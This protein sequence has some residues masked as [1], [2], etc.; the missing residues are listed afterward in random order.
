MLD[1]IQLT[2]FA[3]PLEGSVKLSDGRR[4]GYAEY[5]GRQGSP[6]FHFHRDPGS[7]LEAGILHETAAALGV[8]LIGVDRPGT[9]HDP[10]PRRRLIDWP[11]D[12]AELADSLG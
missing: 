3:E 1:A 7:R 10:K 9:G 2:E 11:S 5:G 12:V 6:V 8:R 4:L